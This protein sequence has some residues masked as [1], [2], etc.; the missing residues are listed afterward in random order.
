MGFAQA[1]MGLIADRAD[2]TKPTLYAHFGDKAAHRGKP[3]APAPGAHLTSSQ[4]SDVGGMRVQDT[5]HQ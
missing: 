3:R 4:S 1:T 5:S 2:S